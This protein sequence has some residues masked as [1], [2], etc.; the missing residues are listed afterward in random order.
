MRAE[1]VVR[2]TDLYRDR[3]DAAQKRAQFAA[4][5]WPRVD[6]SAGDKSTMGL[7]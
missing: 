1:S 2:L 7:S 3:P 5:F 4:R 6:K